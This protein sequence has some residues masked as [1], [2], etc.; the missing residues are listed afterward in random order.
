MNIFAVHE[1]PYVAAQQLCDKHVVKMIVEG[2]QMLSTIH[3]MS[4]SHVVYAP[5]ELYKSCF[6]NHPC[7]IWARKTTENYYWLAN[8][9]LELSREYSYR[10]SGK[11]HKSHDMCVWFSQHVPC[12]VPYGELTQFAQ[13][14]PDKYK[15]QSSVIAYRKYYVN[16]KMRFAKWKYS[17]KPEWIDDENLKVNDVPMQVLQS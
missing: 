10:Y 14:M 11:I 6:E 9:T 3:R 15:D 13:A 1:S 5:V 4:S 16:E 2:C 17:E 12:R 7:T 8:H